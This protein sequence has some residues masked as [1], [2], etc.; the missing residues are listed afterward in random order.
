MRNRQPVYDNDR[1]D[2]EASGHAWVV[3]R[4]IE[5]RL[6]RGVRMSRSTGQNKQMDACSDGGRDA[7]MKHEKKTNIT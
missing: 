6:F 2:A 4:A 1:M 3:R 5:D 7:V